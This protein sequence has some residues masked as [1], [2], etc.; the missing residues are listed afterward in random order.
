MMLH[1]LQAI[2]TTDRL[3]VHVHLVVRNEKMIRQLETAS[4]ATLTFTSMYG[5]DGSKLDVVDY[6]SLSELLGYVRNAYVRNYY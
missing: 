2:N 1:S 3:L 5:S 4:T 6:C